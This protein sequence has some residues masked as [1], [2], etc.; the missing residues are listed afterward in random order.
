LDF[1]QLRARVGSAARQL[2]LARLN[3]TGS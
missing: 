3:V 2:A 1:D